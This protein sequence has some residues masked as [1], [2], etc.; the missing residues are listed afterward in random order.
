MRADEAHHYDHEADERE[1]RVNVR[2]GPLAQAVACCPVP[3]EVVL[4]THFRG[5]ALIDE[6]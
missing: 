1:I 4:C 5:F 2:I 6:T 3:E